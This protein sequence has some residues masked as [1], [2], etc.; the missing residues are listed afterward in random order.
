MNKRK[1][2]KRGI[3]GLAALSIAYFAWDLNATSKLESALEEARAQ[4]VPLTMAD[5]IEGRPEGGNAAAHMYAAALSMCQ[6]AGDVSE[7]ALDYEPFGDAGQAKQLAEVPAALRAALPDFAEGI[8]LLQR[9]GEVGECYFPMAE[10]ESLDDRITNWDAMRTLDL[11]R[12]L[13]AD[14]K[15]HMDEG[16][17]EAAK[18]A[19]EANLALTTAHRHEPT[20][21]VQLVGMITANYGAR[22]A[23]LLAPKL[24]NPAEWLAGLHLL[25]GTEPGSNTPL[26]AEALASELPYFT[27]ALGGGE[28][29]TS[30]QLTQLFGASDMELPGTWSLAAGTPYMRS[31]QASFIKYV[32]ASIA[33]A[34]AP[35]HEAIG[36]ADT[37]ANEVREESNSLTIAF[38]INASPMLQNYAASLAQ[39]RLLL[40]GTKAYAHRAATGSWPT[41][42]A[43]LGLADLLDPRTGTPFEL[44]QTGTTLTL[45]SQGPDPVEW[46]LD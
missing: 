6:A 22:S 42:I 23:M 2:I 3:L 46:V 15:V 17:L 28:D 18:R 11:S 41:D 27:Q 43:S 36:Q 44:H 21:I 12:L 14:A 34:K 35:L 39:T 25:E 19:I 8:A 38:V 45:A 10:G 40:L 26:I 5:L 31:A 4:G 24:D 9:A 16:D 7:L 29:M 30:E 13:V 20:L 37:L 1:I 32:T 33:I